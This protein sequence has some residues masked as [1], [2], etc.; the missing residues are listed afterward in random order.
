MKLTEP[1]LVLT[2]LGNDLEPGHSTTQTIDYSWLVN[3]S[4]E[5]SRQL[6]NGLKSS[7]DQVGIT[8]F[9]KCPSVEDII[10]TEGNIRVQVYDDTTLKFTGFLS[11]NYQ[12]TLTD[13]GE[14]ALQ[15]TIESVG[16]R[17]FSK[18]FIE[19]GHYFFNTS[20]SAAIYAI[21]NP[22]GIPFRSGDER[23]LLQ[24][25][26]KDIDA[27]KSC[28][29]I[30]DSL[31]YECNAV[32]FFNER[33]ELCIFNITA[34]TTGAQKI[35]SAHLFNSK[36]KSI[37]LSKSLRTYKGARVQYA[38]TAS[39]TNYLV[40]RNTTGQDSVHP[41]CHLKLGAGEWFD[42]AE[43]YT[44]AEWSAATADTFR[45]P[46][47]ISA[48]NASS[49]SSIV[50]SNEIL[51]I[52]NAV[53]DVIA[54]TG[55]TV[56]IEAV[57]GKWFK[58]TCHNTTA[59]D[60]YIDKLDLKADIV[61]QKSDGIIRTQ[62]TGSTDGKSLLEEEM[63]WIHD[64]DNAQKHANLL[65]QYYKSCGANYTFYSD[66][67]IPLGSVIELNDDVFSG[68]DVF[69]LVYA[70]KTSASSDICEY[71]AVGITTFNLAEA[72][73][74]GTTEPAKQSGAQG[75]QGEPGAST[76]VQ[77]ARGT[78]LTNPP[79]E[80]MQWNGV[81]MLWDGQVML[82]STDLYSDTVPEAARGEY[83]WMRTKVG[84]APWQYSRLTGSASYDP[85]F[86][87][88]VNSLPTQTPDGLNLIDGDYFVA[89]ENF[90]NDNYLEGFA[91]IY[92]GSTWSMMD[93]EDVDNA[94]KAL[95]CLGGILASGANVANATKSIWGWFANLVA[96]NAVID[97][98]FSQAIT[99][100]T[101]GHIESVDFVAPF[102]GDV[103]DVDTSGV[104]S[105]EGF[106]F[107]ESTF[108]S[109]VSSWG[110]G[111][112][113]F[114]CTS[115]GR[116]NGTWSLYQDSTL[117]VSGLNNNSTNPSMRSYGVYISFDGEGAV[118]RTDDE[119]IINYYRSTI[120]G[121]GFHLGSDGT[122]ICS[123]ATV[124]GDS[125]FRGRFDCDVIKTEVDTTSSQSISVTDTT[126]TQGSTVATALQSAGFSAGVKIAATISGATNPVRF[127]SYSGEN[128]YFF[129]ENFNP[130][131]I[132]DYFS[133]KQYREDTGAVS[134]ADSTNQIGRFKV[135]K[136]TYL[137][138]W[139]KYYMDNS[140][141][142]TAYN[143]G[144]RLT[145]DIPDNGV[146][147]EFG[148]LFYGAQ[149]QVGGIN[150]YPVYMA[151]GS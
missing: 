74:H 18:P 145:V 75:A 13:H 128:V 68:L 38:E 146:G 73:Y 65:A 122:F 117:K 134:T 99:I 42:G 4:A 28:R 3:R 89:S 31:F 52:S 47:L 81:D 6:L 114:K 104:Q 7:S 127:I 5:L 22:L 61:Y 39:A 50:G 36:G 41:F 94:P 63:T 56:S 102:E 148:Q 90:D 124:S 92:N 11:T 71:K 85:I 45:E 100:L 147:L 149:T 17:L 16:T 76:I 129:D 10:A 2:F 19:T 108:V 66:L 46:T 87:G 35:D 116:Y 96:Q 30:L 142:I 40:Y 93:L 8:L 115:G 130:V 34:D 107:V 62:V 119:I 27:G 98:L 86:L 131:D 106:S 1:S 120:P 58:I 88:A 54:E 80:A 141:T 72:V 144:N 59:Y 135:D 9:R 25:I 103:C 110:Y 83:I 109:A 26:Q 113:K 95:Q 43:I 70:Q 77:Y 53:Q 112:Y 57:G 33:G 21:I 136:G 121:Q 133:V 12:W 14:Q 24:P 32:Y 150:C 123:N 15:L 64:K 138:Y 23:K 48:V 84:D 151:K 37:S 60:R 78:S 139:V 111:V 91:Y 97:N 82:W 101:G 51:A 105:Y 137:R 29:E 125:F 140:Y 118:A 79:S 143:G 126:K 55:I 132:A 44:A 67:D 20:A 69:V 49:E